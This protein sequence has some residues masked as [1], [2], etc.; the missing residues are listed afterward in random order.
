[1]KLKSARHAAVA[2]TIEAS[3]HNQQH[4]WGELIKSKQ[5]EPM[6]L[7]L[8]MAD[9]LSR[10]SSGERIGVFAMQHGPGTENAFGGVAQAYGDSVPIVVLPAGYAR[11]KN[12]V[13]PNFNSLLNFMRL[14][15]FH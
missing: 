14:L 1:M 6:L 3:A 4:P 2:V 11:G 15:F 10:V 12:Q 8:H 5:D 7:G 13:M 9:A